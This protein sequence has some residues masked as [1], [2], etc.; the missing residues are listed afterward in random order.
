VALVVQGL[1]NVEVGE[2]LF[3]SRRTVQSHLSH[4]YHKLGIA[5]RRDL[6]REA[7]GWPPVLLGA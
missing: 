4:V 5:C 1:T 7:A 2:R 6:A 3:I